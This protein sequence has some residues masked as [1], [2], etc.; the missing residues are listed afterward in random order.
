MLKKAVSR[1]PIRSKKYRAIMAGPSVMQ[2][3][4]SEGGYLLVFRNER[5][6]ITTLR[7]LDQGEGSPYPL[8]VLN[9]INKRMM[10]NPSL[11]S[12]FPLR[13]A[14]NGAVNNLPKQKPSI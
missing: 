3:Y 2:E 8:M 12:I 4:I 13:A 7:C 9:R 1:F 5:M 10:P 6:L 11:I 14:S